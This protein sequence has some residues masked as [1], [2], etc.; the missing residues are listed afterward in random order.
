MG[1]YL[2]IEKRG[3]KARLLLPQRSKSYHLKMPLLSFLFFCLFETGSCHVSL[4]CLN[5]R[6]LLPHHLTLPSPRLPVCRLSQLQMATHFSKH[7][8]CFLFRYNYFEV[9]YYLKWFLNF[10]ALRKGYNLRTLQIK[11]SGYY[12]NNTCDMFKIIGLCVHMCVAR[13]D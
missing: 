10:T 8:F 1:F 11:I 5:F 9:E 13:M 2:F 7:S 6:L 4:A 12:K 3:I